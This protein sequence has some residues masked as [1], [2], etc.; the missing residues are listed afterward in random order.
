MCA[1]M[2]EHVLGCAHSTASGV[3]AWNDKIVQ[4]HG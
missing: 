1:E 2:M 4:G 3:S